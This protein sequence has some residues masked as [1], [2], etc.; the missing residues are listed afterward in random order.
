MV[1]CKVDLFYFLAFSVVDIYSEFFALGRT[2]VLQYVLLELKKWLQVLMILF[3]HK[4][5][6]E[7]RS[8][9]GETLIILVFVVGY[10]SLYG[11]GLC[12][13]Y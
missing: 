3:K 2:C 1:G 7:F 4:Y 9:C 11:L 13:I 12:R 6:V 10:D 5:S 8:K